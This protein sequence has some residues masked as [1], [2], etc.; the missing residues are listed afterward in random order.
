MIRG[1]QSIRRLLLED[2][3]PPRIVV[4]EELDHHV[5][6]DDVS[7]AVVAEI[8]NHPDRYPGTKIVSLSRRTYPEGTLAAHVLGHLGSRGRRRFRRTDIPV[9][10]T[11]RVGRMGVERQYEALLRGQPGVAV[12]QLDHGGR[13]VHSY[14]RQEPTAGRDLELTLDVRLQRTAEELLQSAL[15]RC[16]TFWRKRDRSVRTLFGRDKWS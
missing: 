14:C 15:K 9:C 6:A 1:P 13:A 11:D 8:E 2:P 16:R 3:P 4:T 10:P 5:M 12:E 7:A